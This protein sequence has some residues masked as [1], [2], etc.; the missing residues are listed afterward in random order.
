[1]ILRYGVQL[2]GKKKKVN[3]K[4]KKPNKLLPNGKYRKIDELL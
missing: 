4:K 1:M 3:L 2:Q